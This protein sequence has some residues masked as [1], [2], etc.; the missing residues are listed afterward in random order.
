MARIQASCAL[1]AGACAYALT[2][3]HNSARQTAGSAAGCRRRVCCAASGMARAQLCQT[4]PGATDYDAQPHVAHPA[5][6]GNRRIARAVWRC[7]GDRQLRHFRAPVGDRTDRDRVLARLSRAAAA[8]A[9]GLARAARSRCG[10]RR[11]GAAGESARSDVPVGRGVL[12][13]GPGAVALIAP[14]HLDCRLDAGSELR[15]D[16]GDAL[17]LGVVGRAAAARISSRQSRWLS[18]A[19]C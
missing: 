18:P 5:P 3:P 1:S 13:R 14:A 2:Q 12:R 8:G 15:A 4:P 6:L 10:A 19:C 17:R 16:A 7:A 9:V 11:R